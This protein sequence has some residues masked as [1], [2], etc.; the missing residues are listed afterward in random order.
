MKHPEWVMKCKIPGSEIRHIKGRYYLYGRTSK[1]CP[2]K[3]R[4]KKVTL[5]QIGIITQEYGLIPTG[6]SRKGKVPPGASKLKEDP[7]IQAGF[8]DEFEKKI[9]DPRATR[10]RLY[11]IAE[12]FLTAL[13]AI[14]CGAEAWADIENYGKAKISTLRKFFDFKNGIPSGRYFSKIFSSY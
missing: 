3:K 6:M 9:T 2:I 5:K 7:K 12:I 10:N 14:L 1:W 4:P 8:L 11:T 13:L